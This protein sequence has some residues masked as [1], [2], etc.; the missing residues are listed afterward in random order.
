M[1]PEVG[2]EPTT[3]RL[4]A[5][6]SAIEL[7]RID[8]K[9][10]SSTAALPCYSK[11]RRHRQKPPPSDPIIASMNPLAPQD[12]LT[13]PHA[14]ASPGKPATSAMSITSWQWPTELDAC[15]AA[16]D[17]H[18]LLFENASVRVLDISIAPGHTVPLHTHCWPASLYL[19]S[20]SHCIRRDA[21]GT[22]LMDS[23]TS[24]PPA[25][26]T[27]TWSPAMAPH[28]LENVGNRLL[29]IISTELKTP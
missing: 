9:Q 27:V 6:C 16:P 1:A 12:A 11:P 3:L 18:V 24:P 23:R 26:G 29:R 7:L 22:I 20:W 21:A 19:V 15:L 13:P 8:R 14:S 17:H 5:E 2:L 28:T 25:E 10:R 4:T